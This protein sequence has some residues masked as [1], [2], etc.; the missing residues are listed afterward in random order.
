MRWARFV[1]TLVVVVS[2][3]GCAYIGA[4]GSA[5]PEATS[6]APSVAT[7]AS[8]SPP[9]SETAP[10]NPTPIPSVDPTP[11]PSQ[12]PPDATS[13]RPTAAPTT[14]CESP[15]PSPS[16][17]AGLAASD[18]FWAHWYESCWFGAFPIVSSLEEITSQ[19]D[20]VVRGTI[21]DL[22]SRNQGIYQLAYL[23]VSITE[24]LKGE[25]MSRDDGTV[26]VQIGLGS[27][28]DLEELRSTLPR[29]DHLFFLVHDDDNE[30]SYYTTD[31]EQVSVLRDI[32][33]VVEVITPEAIAGA[34]SARHFP[35]PL[36]GTS[37]EELIARVR[38][39][40]SRPPAAMYAYVRRPPGQP[41]PNISAAC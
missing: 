11:T 2:V 5:S 19:S 13:H 23:R 12:T 30:Y 40:A 41:D 22:Y 4:N 36:D 27:S 33:G 6:P 16:Q 25:P 29:H 14:C 21:I 17:V 26:E 37:F 3:G 39:L 10:T 31:Y 18:R 35:V 20:L 8:P 9:P 28:S 34:Y 32:G 38:E 15:S 1:A 24:V 7:S